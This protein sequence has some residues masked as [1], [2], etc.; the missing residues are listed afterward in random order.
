VKKESQSRKNSPDDGPLITPLDNGT[1]V[2]I[3]NKP[4]SE[5]VAVAIGFGVGSRYES[6]KTA[7]ISHILEH[8]FFKGTQSRTYRQIAQQ[9]DGL[10]AS[11]NAFTQ[12]D[13]TV[14][15]A[16][17]P[18]ENFVKLIDLWSDMLQNSILDEK[19]FEKEREVV[20]QEYMRYLDNG[21]AMTYANAYQACFPKNTLGWPI[22]GTEEALRSITIDDVRGYW[23]K[24][25]Q[26][27]NLIISVVGRVNKEIALRTIN[28]AFCDMVA[29]NRATFKPVS[30]ATSTLNRESSHWLSVYPKDKNETHFALCGRT[31]SATDPNYTSL[32]VLNKMVGGSRRS[33]LYQRLITEYGY[34]SLVTSTYE[35][36]PDTG[37]F[38]V[39][40]SMTPKHA[41][42][43]FEILQEEI[44]KIIEKRPTEKMTN[45]GKSQIS[46]EITIELENTFNLSLWYI[47]MYLRHQRLITPDM[48]LEDLQTVTPEIIHPNLKEI[49][50]PEQMR[51]IM[52]G[53]IPKE[54]RKA[55][56]SFKPP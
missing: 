42:K 55:E 12:R 27:N 20:L 21:I 46:G 53:K 10:G 30:P 50:S 19:E 14:Y 9:F 6:K 32:A 4:H 35:L 34:A 11:N 22:I 3:D 24:M 7:G 23:K 1:Q 26:P 8:M 40:T 28:Q 31:I 54:L 33:P 15:Y 56:F 38:V 25:Y 29:G 2:I 18:H 45:L 16:K 37:I 49:F 52:L 51:M 44:Q 47:Q 39:L 13:M 36:F 5:S 17:S 43:T 48:F 41:K